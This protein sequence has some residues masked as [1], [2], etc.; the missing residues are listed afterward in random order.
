MIVHVRRDFL[1]LAAADD[2]AALQTHQ[3][4]TPGG[5]RKGQVIFMD[6]G[7]STF[8]DGL[9]GA[10]QSFFYTKFAERGLPFDRMLNWEVTAQNP[11]KL[12][13]EVPGEIFSNYQYFNVSSHLCLCFALK[14]FP[15][16]SF[17]L[18]I[19]IRLEIASG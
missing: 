1:F 16:G 2:P 13:G 17:L 7:A 8:N 12:L 18:Y 14:G 6:L 9:G 15:F 5:R 11:T 4:F 10:S 3:F 19:C